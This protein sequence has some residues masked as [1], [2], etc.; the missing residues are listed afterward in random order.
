VRYNSVHGAQLINLNSTTAEISFYA[1][2]DPTNPYATFVD[3]YRLTKQANGTISYST[4]SA[5]APPPAAP[6]YSL[7]TGALADNTAGTHNRVLWR[8]TSTAAVSG[9][10]AAWATVG[11]GDGS[12]QLGATRLG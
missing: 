5:I 9:I 3:C 10:D 4:C 1:A 8:Y 11:F 6:Q 7:L 2:T 12:W